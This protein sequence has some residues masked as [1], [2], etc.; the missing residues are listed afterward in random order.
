MEKVIYNNYDLWE[1]YPDEDLIEHAIEEGWID[2]EE[3]DDVSESQ[4]QAWRYLEDD[5]DWENAEY[6]LK[7]FFNGKDVIMVGTVGRWDG[8]YAGGKVGEFWELYHEAVRDCDYI[9]I[10]EK[11]GHFYIECSHYDGTN[12]F[13][14]KILTENGKRYLNNWEYNWSNKKTEREIHKQIMKRYSKLPKFFKTVYE[15]A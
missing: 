15:A 10:Y 1:T 4:I 12:H 13:E 6:E 9:K 7:N 3:K 8:N 5:F 14:V 2:E 11:G